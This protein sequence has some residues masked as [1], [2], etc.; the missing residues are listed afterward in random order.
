MKRLLAMLC[1]A[2]ALVGCGS[3]KKA[4]FDGVKI[5]VPHLQASYD[6][7]KGFDGWTTMRI[8]VGQTVVRFDNAGRVIPWLASYEGNVFTVRDIKFSDGSKV[9]A[10]D[11]CASLDNSCAKSA[12]AK[13]VMKNSS[14]RVL[15]DQQFEYKGEVSILSDPL[16]CISKN[17]LY[18]GGKVLS[19]SDRKAEVERNGK[20]YQYLAVSDNVARG[21]AI[22]KGEVDIAYDVDRHFYK[23]REVQELGSARTIMGRLNMAPGRAL[24]DPKLR[25]ALAEAINLKDMEK[26]LQ[27][28][29][30]CNPNYSRFT[31]SNRAYKPTQVEPVTLELLYYDSRPEFRTIAE[32]TQIQA[33]EVGIN[34]KLVPM[35]LNAFRRAELSGAFDIVLSST[36]NVQSG[37]VE[38]Y[39]RMY[40]DSRSVENTT[41]YSN[42]A[43]DNAPSLQAMQDVLDQDY[44]VIV[45][46]NPIHNRVSKEKLVALNPLDIY[47]DVDKAGEQTNL[48]AN[49]N[50]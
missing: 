40:F 28:Y 34:I 14:W 46:G 19:Y 18:T 32:A 1:V 42:P 12:R 39:Y 7:T 41:K 11:I 31:K 35:P 4:D 2:L 47:Y 48:L 36:N 5:A 3:N 22:Q 43:F 25:Q 37:S 50:K 8:G 38:N 21:Y 20:K 30:D 23:G 13:A 9:T 6:H 17:G 44:A 26:P 49:A 16:F 10:K 33:K 24:N 45:Y 29:V 15:N 27:G